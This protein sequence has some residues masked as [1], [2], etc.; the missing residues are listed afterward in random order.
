MLLYNHING[1]MQFGGKD[2]DVRLNI[3]EYN[4]DLFFMEVS[5]EF[6]VG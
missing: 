2:T 5:C 4:I 6:A 3:K 1:R